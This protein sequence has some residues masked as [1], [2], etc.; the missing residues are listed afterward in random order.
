MAAF[1]LAG[2]SPADTDEPGVCRSHGVAEQGMGRPIQEAKAV[3]TDEL[4]ALCRVLHPDGYH[5]SG[6]TVANRNG[7]V[8]I[9]WAVGDECAK[10]HEYC[11]AKHGMA[12]TLR[13]LHDVNNKH[14]RP[15]CPSSQ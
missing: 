14:P 2:C 12:H 11:H 13:Y 10:T 15:A 6:C 7:T 5:L 8:S 9:Y 3:Y 1:L 4:P